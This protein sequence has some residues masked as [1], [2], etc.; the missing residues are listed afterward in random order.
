MLKLKGLRI[1]SQHHIEGEHIWGTDATQLQDLLEPTLIKT[2]V[3]SVKEQETDEWSR[4]EGL[5]KG[6]HKYI[7]AI[8]DRRIKV[9]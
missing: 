3:M 4:M 6:P 8:F 5:E 7:Q 2:G 9:I 1:N